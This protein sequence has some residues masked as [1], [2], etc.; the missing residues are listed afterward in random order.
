MPKFSI[1][2]TQGMGSSEIKVRPLEVNEGSSPKVG[3]VVI[4]LQD[5]TQKTITLTQLAGERSYKYFL[6]VNP[7]DVP[8]D[9]LGST[10]NVYVESYRE[11][12]VNG[13]M[14]GT[15]EVGYTIQGEPGITVQGDTITIGANSS[16]M[17]VVR[18]ATVI[19]DES[20]KRVI[21]TITQSA[22]S[23]ESSYT[24]TA[25]PMFVT[26]GT[27]GGSQAINIVS[28][29]TTTVNGSTGSPVTLDYTASISPGFTWNGTSIQATENNSA[30]ELTG[31]LV[32]TQSESNLQIT[33]EIT[34]EAA[35]VSDEY[36][37]T[38]DPTS[39]TIENTGGTLTPTIKSVHI[40]QVGSD[41]QEVEVGYSWNLDN[42]PSWITFQD[43][44][45][46]IAENMDTENPRSISLQ[47]V[48]E[49]SNK[50][51]TLSITQHKAEYIFLI[52]KNQ[53]EE[54]GTEITFE[55]SAD[56]G[57]IDRPDG[58]GNEDTDSVWLY[59]SWLNSRLHTIGFDASTDVEWITVV[60][61]P[62]SDGFTDEDVSEPN[63]PGYKVQDN[64]TQ[65]ARSGTVTL[66]QNHSGKKCYIHINQAGAVAGTTYE[67]SGPATI[68]VE[69][70]GGSSFLNIKST[71]QET[72]GGVP[73]GE[74][75][76]VGYTLTGNDM[77]WVEVT[78][79]SP[80]TMQVEIN[81]DYESDRSGTLTFKQDESGKTLT[82]KVTQ[83]AK[84]LVPAVFTF[85]DGTTTK[86]LT[87]DKP[88][89]DDAKSFA[90][91][92]LDPFNIIL[93]DEGGVEPSNPSFTVS[94]SPKYKVAIKN[95]HYSLNYQKSGST[96]QLLWVLN[97]D[98]EAVF[99]LNDGTITVTIECNNGDNQ[100][101]KLTL[102]LKFA[103][104][105]LWYRLQVPKYVENLGS[106][107][108]IPFTLWNGSA[109]FQSYG[110]TETSTQ[111]SPF[112]PRFGVTTKFQGSGLKLELP[113]GVTP[114][115]SWQ[116][117]TYCYNKV[118]P[119]FMYK[120]NPIM[121][122]HGISN[123]DFI[124]HYQR[125]DSP[126]QFRVLTTKSYEFQINNGWTNDETYSTSNLGSS[127]NPK[128]AIV[129]GDGVVWQDE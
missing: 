78:G 129:V 90:K 23:S 55:H 54:P 127:T 126:N 111:Y 63:K 5:G 84:P 88:L 120:Y 128:F 72:V 50:R 35:E 13:Q 12:Y 19:Q 20:G 99:G 76:D 82:I 45:F 74:A 29:K 121:S 73:Q 93:L 125:N 36:Q 31:T 66:L 11:V 80:K 14:I 15:E 47:A 114:G 9:P 17:E 101:K 16:N 39:S 123:S 109:E 105:Q 103:G 124:I 25:D 62:V 58:S 67:F 38:I 119:I 116:S 27:S 102:N 40:T 42:L 115:Q 59:R 95:F 60:N 94:Y 2:K 89:D 71:K 65:E 22:G 10:V 107:G 48:Q 26:F 61:F 106:S 7:M 81:N 51:V 3:H 100:G 21:I 34:Q 32:L 112:I 83:K 113:C 104:Y 108:L 86:S 97:L 41:M 96:Q 122:I 28:T 68:T 43:G 30:S 70:E 117:G 110:Y 46:T 64:T 4:T 87:I 79:S 77:D 18:R 1:D 49:E 69:P 92:T 52:R 85:A 37:F 75:V 91:L 57:I 44:T 118:V 24:F 6:E 33:V 98:H 56:S 8:V 53:Q